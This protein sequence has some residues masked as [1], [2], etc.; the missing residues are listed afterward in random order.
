MLYPSELR[1]RSRREILASVYT[2]NFGLRDAMLSV[3]VTLCHA[4]LQRGHG[5]APNTVTWFAVPTYTCPFTTVGTLNLIA[6][7]ARSRA[8]ACELL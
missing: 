2:S 7:P 5:N 3:E 8:P 4:T 1:G 6:C